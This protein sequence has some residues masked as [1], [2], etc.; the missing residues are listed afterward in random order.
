VRQQQGHD[1]MRQHGKRQR[2]RCRARG[3]DKVTV[4]EVEGIGPA[5]NLGRRVGTCSRRWRGWPE[6]RRIAVQRSRAAPEEEEKGDFPR[7]LF[8]K[9]KNYRDPTVN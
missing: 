5:L 1:E 3:E 7:D 2:T 9:L 4:E 6:Q 8:V